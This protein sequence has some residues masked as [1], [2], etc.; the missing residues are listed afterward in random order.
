MSCKWMFFLI[1]LLSS[2][3]LSNT[4]FIDDG[5]KTYVYMKILERDKILIW[6]GG[7]T[8]YF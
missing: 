6:E 7:N 8:Y 1:D 4:L 5:K 3:H 2:T